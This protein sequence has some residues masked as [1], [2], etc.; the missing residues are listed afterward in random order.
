MPKET[1]NY[2]QKK[3]ASQFRV[4]YN[5]ILIQKPSWQPLLSIFPSEKQLDYILVLLFAG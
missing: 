4:V 1:E 2:Y 5:S 3:D